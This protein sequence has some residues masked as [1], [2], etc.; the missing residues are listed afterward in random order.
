MS[1]VRNPLSLAGIVAVACMLLI[2]GK[3]RAE[4]YRIVNVWSGFALEM[5]IDKSNSYPAKLQ[6]SAKNDSPNQVWDVIHDGT[7]KIIQ[8]KESGLLLDM[9]MYEGGTK[10]GNPLQLHENNGQLNQRWR[11]KPDANGDL[12]IVNA[13]SG[14]LLDMPIS[15]GGPTNGTKIQMHSDN[16]QSN[17]RWRLLEVVSAESAA[18]TSPDASETSSTSE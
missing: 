8:H 14:H 4:G 6:V 7:K 5:T 1:A 9:P 10:N 17:Q 2:P 18:A 13:W 11:F 15:A 16:G 12:R 3:G